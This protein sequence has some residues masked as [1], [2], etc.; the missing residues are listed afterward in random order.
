VL[1]SATGPGQRDWTWRLFHSG[2]RFSLLGFSYSEFPFDSHSHSARSS[3]LVPQSSSVRT[4][5]AAPAC[6]CRRCGAGFPS[7]TQKLHS[8]A[9]PNLRSDLL[10][11]PRR[12]FTPARGIAERNEARHSGQS[13]IPCRRWPA[14]LRAT[15]RN[16]CDHSDWIHDRNRIVNRTRRPYVTN[17]AFVITPPAR[18]TRASGRT[19]CLL[20][21]HNDVLVRLEVAEQNGNNTSQSSRF[22]PMEPPSAVCDPHYRAA[23]VRASGSLSGG[24]IEIALTTA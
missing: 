15:A 14:R 19:G 7:S 16:R 10:S 4:R 13:S 3:F 12:Q 17:G 21:V 5:Q 22:L 9:E 20:A 23:S 2:R 1:S 6:L 11:G 24:R 8:N 18:E